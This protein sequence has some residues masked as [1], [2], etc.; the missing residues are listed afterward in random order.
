MA[1]M[2]REPQEDIKRQN[3]RVVVSRRYTMTVRLAGK[4]AS[5]FTLM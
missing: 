4:V 5:D 3:K 1:V 2:Y